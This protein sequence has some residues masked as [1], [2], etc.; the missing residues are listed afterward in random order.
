MSTAA[1]YAESRPILGASSP[2]VGDAGECVYR[3]TQ[4]AVGHVRAG[5]AA[6]S[7]F[8][9]NDLR[10][11]ANEVGLDGQ[12]SDLFNLA[13]QFLLALPASA[14]TPELSMDDD[15]DISFDWQGSGG[16]LLSISLRADGRLSY[17]S[18]VSAYDR[19]HGTKQF[20]DAIPT[21]ILE[22]VA[23]VSGG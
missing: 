22:L 8:V 7:N 10:N 11:L 3:I 14:P 4:D 2:A 5:V 6:R 23:R 20:D 19:D 12:R 9:F 13:Q 16:A 15:G 17:A 1:N 18:R 21:R